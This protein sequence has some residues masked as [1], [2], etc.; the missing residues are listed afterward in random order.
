MR[1][2]VALFTATSI[3]LVA[4]ILSAQ[5]AAV[6]AKP[7]T[8]SDVA[9]LRQDLQKNKMEVISSE[10]QFTKVE[11]DA[12][13]PVYR[14]YAA[15]QNK[16]S[17]KR[18]DIIHEYARNIEN[19]NSAKAHDLTLG[20]MSIEEDYLALKKNYLP[21]FEKVIGE[22]RAAK[23]FQVDN[24]LSLLVNIQLAGQIPVIPQ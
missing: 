11:E 16:I 18:L 12:F 9:L 23:F 3:L 1:G 6:S 2:I 14:E 13:W 22:K 8:E 19:L 17:A 21:S 24:R 20:M 5:D 10:M 7:L 4:G 15:A